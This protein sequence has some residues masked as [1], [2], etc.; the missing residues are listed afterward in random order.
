MTQSK[1][2]LVLAA[3][4]N[5][6]TDRVPVGFWFHFLKDEIHSNSFEHPEFIEELFQGQTKYIDTA[7]PDFVKIMT[8]GFFP[9]ENKTVQH[10][11]TAEDFKHIQ[12]LAD[13]DP[14]FTTQIAY[15]K[16]LTDKYG[17]DLAMFYNVFCAGTTIKFMRDDISTSEEY[18]AQLVR[19]DPQAV[20]QGLDVISGDLAKLAKRL[21]TEGGVTGIYLS[22]Q[23]L[24][25]EGDDDTTGQSQEAVASLGGVMGLQGQTHLDNAPAQ[26][27]ETHGPDQAEDK[28]TQ[29]VDHG[30][31]IIGSIGG[32]GQSQD[33]SAGEYGAAVAAEALADIFGHGQTLR[34]TTGGMNDV[35]DDVFHKL[36]PVVC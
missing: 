14:W 28:G 5:K 27:N 10:L 33:H 3:M 9:Y 4:D 17:A 15:A 26:Q 2:E 13:D 32:H 18:L 7:K 31:R 23:N 20:R 8:D 30:Q 6:A 19:E 11:E 12:P 1:K 24:L 35:V 36:P 22:L 34:S 25:G 29:V 16:R 21:I